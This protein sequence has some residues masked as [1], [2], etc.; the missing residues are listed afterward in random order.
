MK[1]KTKKKRVDKK[2]VYHIPDASS[3]KYKQKDKS[4][5]FQMS[6]RHFTPSVAAAA[7]QF[8]VFLLAGKKRILNFPYTP[9]DRMFHE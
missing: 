7:R 1:K 8:V 4:I 5:S 9:L 3:N 6:W 2:Y